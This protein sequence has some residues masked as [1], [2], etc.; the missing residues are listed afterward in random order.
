P[1]QQVALVRGF[2]SLNFEINRHQ[3]LDNDW[4]WGEEAQKEPGRK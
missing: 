1:I 3:F 2:R 4:R